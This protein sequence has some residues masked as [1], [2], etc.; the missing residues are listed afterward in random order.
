MAVIAI[1]AMSAPW[2][3]GLGRTDTLVCWLGA[4]TAWMTGELE[5]RVADLEYQIREL[6]R[7]TSKDARST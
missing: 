2:L 7:I 4:F 6:Q 3:L 1:G 5:M